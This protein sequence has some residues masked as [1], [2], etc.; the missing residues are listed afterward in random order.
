MN[1]KSFV[2]NCIITVFVFIGAWLTFFVHDDSSMLI[3]DGI[4]NL[5]YHAILV[6]DIVAA[7]GCNKADAPAERR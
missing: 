7:S 5:K 1:K 3:T 6:V 2:T 4:E